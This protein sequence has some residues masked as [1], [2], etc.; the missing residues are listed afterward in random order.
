MNGNRI[1]NPIVLQLG[2]VTYM[3]HDWTSNGIRGIPSGF[4]FTFSYDGRSWAK[5]QL[6]ALPG[7][8][9]APM[10]LLETAPGVLSIW[11][12]SYRG[13][14][15]DSS[16]FGSLHVARFNLTWSANDDEL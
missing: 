8:I 4:G 11:F 2:N 16:Y 3:V 12:N 5:S 14:S 1:E 10:G 13:D 15:D 6:V 7:G 9:R